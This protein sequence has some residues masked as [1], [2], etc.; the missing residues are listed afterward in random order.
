[1]DEMDGRTLED[2]EATTANVEMMVGLTMGL[3]M[4]MME[5][6][7]LQVHALSRTAGQGVAD[8]YTE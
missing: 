6:T 4:A 2:R 8:G 1:M 7:G 5:A 3:A